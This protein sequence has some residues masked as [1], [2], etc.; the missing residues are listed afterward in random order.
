MSPRRSKAAHSSFAGVLFS[1]PVSR[2]SIQRARVYRGWENRAL[3]LTGA[4][5]PSLSQGQRRGLD[6]GA[7]SS[8]AARATFILG[9]ARKMQ[10]RGAQEG[11]NEMR[12]PVTGKWG[13]EGCGE[14]AA[15]TFARRQ[16]SEHT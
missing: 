8:Q 12:H 3:P 2:A 14:A 9:T 5:R 4:V 7:R 13:T 10:V 16:M 15:A 6:P 1:Y 11:H